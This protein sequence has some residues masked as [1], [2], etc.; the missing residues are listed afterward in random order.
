MVGL[1]YPNKQKPGTVYTDAHKDITSNKT[2]IS[3][4]SKYFE[5]LLSYP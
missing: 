2:G 3:I 5:I 1:N 4:Y